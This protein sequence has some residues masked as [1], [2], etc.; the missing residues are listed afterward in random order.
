[1]DDPDS[2][3]Q[4]RSYPGGDCL[5][6]Q[7]HRLG[8]DRLNEVHDLIVAAEGPGDPLGDRW[9]GSP[10]DQLGEHLLRDVPSGPLL[11]EQDVRGRRTIQPENAREA[12]ITS[13]S[14]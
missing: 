10:A 12:A 2:L 14:E 5:V 3:L 9:L 7:E 1:L 4:R 8:H 6:G 11:I 13:S